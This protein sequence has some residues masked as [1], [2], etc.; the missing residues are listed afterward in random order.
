MLEE[1]K[2][3]QKENEIY[4]TEFK[5]WLESQD[6]DDKDIKEYMYYINIYINEFLS[7][8]E[9]K[10]PDGYLEIC[11]FFDDWYPNNFKVNKDHV[12]KMC[13]SLKKFYKCM[14]M[15]KHISEENFDFLCEYINM[16]KP[17]LLYN[18]DK[19]GKE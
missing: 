19:Y 16:E 12:H 18:V 14:Y 13:K 9:V 7:Y 5:D 8:C 4:L 6:L 11:L 3:I 1:V 15:K 2:A 17:H 10:M